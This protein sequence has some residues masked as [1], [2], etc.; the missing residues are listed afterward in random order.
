MKSEELADELEALAKDAAPLPWSDTE[1]DEDEQVVIKDEDNLE[2]AT[3]WHHCVRS[4]EMQIHANAALIVALRNNIPDILS[5]LRR[6]AELEVALRFYGDP[7]E[8]PSEG[9]WGVDSTDFG[10]VARQA[11]TGEA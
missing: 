9:P 10:N 8:I 4:L 3:L 6:V 7:H 1:R 5:S 11:L 2:L